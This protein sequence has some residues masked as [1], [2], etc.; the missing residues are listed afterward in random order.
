MVILIPQNILEKQLIRWQVETSVAIKL[1]VL[2]KT[3]AA[4][5]ANNIELL[6]TGLDF[7]VDSR[8]KST[9]CHFCRIH[10]MT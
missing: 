5:R 4:G 7:V 2:T 10:G 1:T 8:L 6:M 9:Q 3:C